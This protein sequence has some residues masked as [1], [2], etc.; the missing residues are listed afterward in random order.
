MPLA[1]RAAGEQRNPPGGVNEESSLPHPPPRPRDTSRVLARPRR[2][3]RLSL[4]I[5]SA[6]C[7]A[8]PRRRQEMATRHDELDNLSADDDS[9]GCDDVEE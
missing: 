7:R 2:G 3:P 5:S 6:W 9:D 1:L 4:I 8:P